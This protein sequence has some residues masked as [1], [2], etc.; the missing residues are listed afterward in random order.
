MSIDDQ[1]GPE[2]WRGGEDSK[3]IMRGRQDP[4]SHPTE[5]EARQQ[6]ENKGNWPL[7]R[8]CSKCSVVVTC[9]NCHWLLISLET[10]NKHNFLGQ[11]DVATI[12][13]CVIIFS[14]NSLFCCLLQN[15]WS[16]A[17]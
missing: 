11:F 6:E 14:S 4:A 16:V 10:E 12:F 7:W 9:T 1:E 3:H 5:E 8:A 13:K 2:G 17:N 15:H